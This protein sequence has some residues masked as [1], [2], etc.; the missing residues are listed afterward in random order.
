MKF[1]PPHIENIKDVLPAIQE[2]PAFLVKEKGWYTVIDYMYMTDKMFHNDVERECRGLKFCSTTGRILA[3]PYHKFHNLNERPDY[4]TDKVDLTLPHVILD[5][6]DGSMVHTC[7]TNMGI[8]LMTRMGITEVAEQADKFMTAN[9]IRF[10]RLFGSMP[11]DEYCY[12]FE[13]VGPNNKIVLDY[14]KED[15]ILTAIRNIYNGAYLYHHEVEALGKAFDVKVVEKFPFDGFDGNM[16]RIANCMKAQSNNEGY[17]IRFASGAMVKIKSDE[18]VRKH[19]SKDLVSSQK[20]IV[21]LIVNGTLDDVMP[22]LDPKVRDQ[23][24]DYEDKL[25]REILRSAEAIALFAKGYAD[26]E[27]KD[28]AL[29]VQATIPKPLQCVAYHV[30]KGCDAR[31]ETLNVVRRNLGTNKRTT[32]LLT[33]LGFPLWTFSF[34]AE[35]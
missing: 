13:Y 22:Q 30:R 11:I 25:S 32:E 31:E 20:G 12:I 7:A 16:E 27:Q 9:Q 3:R 26:L 21:D 8:Y 5:K 34:F 23:V 4:T 14:E 35:E 6:L 33:A 1:N 19:R 28:Y 15:L 2:N 10:S 29:K 18:Y 17:V 24:L